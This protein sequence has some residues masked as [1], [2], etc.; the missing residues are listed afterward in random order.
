MSTETAQ[1]ATAQGRAQVRRWRWFQWSLR[2]LLATM[3]V[4]GVAFG[5]WAHRIRHQ[6]ERDRA[7]QILALAPNWTGWE[8]DPVALVRAVN[9]LQSV[10]KEEAIA[11]LRQF[12]AEYP[13]DGGHDVPHQ[14]LELVVPLLFDRVN[15]EDRYPDTDPFEKQGNYTLTLDAWSTWVEVEDGLPIHTVTLGG[16]SGF[17]ADNTYLIDWAEKHA[18][19]RSTPLVPCDD[20]VGAVD[21]LDARMREKIENDQ[22]SLKAYQWT[23]WHMRRQAYT[24]IQPLLKDDPQDSKWTLGRDED[25]EDFKRYAATLDIRWSKTEQRYVKARASQ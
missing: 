23:A 7:V 8:F 3:L 19:L 1:S 24:A 10:G 25:W 15:P 20:P 18:R 21:R 11:A 6:R 2:S 12:A 4:A 14:A 5:W 13:A 16:T 17:F 9:H 22:E